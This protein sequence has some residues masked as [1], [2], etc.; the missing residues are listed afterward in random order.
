M[1]LMS[2]LSRRSSGIA[3]KPPSFSAHSFKLRPAY[4]LSRKY[5]EL[6]KFHSVRA[7]NQNARPVKIEAGE[8]VLLRFSPRNLSLS[9]ANLNTRLSCVFGCSATRPRSTASGQACE[10]VATVLDAARIARRRNEVR[11]NPWTLAVRCEPALP[12]DSRCVAE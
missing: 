7:Q 2:N 6:S 8:R 12:G 1:A 3:R 5:G 10:S 4:S 9:A 11:G